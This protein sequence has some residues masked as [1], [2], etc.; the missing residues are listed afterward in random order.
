MG[1]D[2]TEK[3]HR[4][5]LSMIEKERVLKEK[6][7]TGFTFNGWYIFLC[8]GYAKFPDWSVCDVNPYTHDWVQAL[9]FRS[10]KK[11]LEYVNNTAY[12]ILNPKN[13]ILTTLYQ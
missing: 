12:H 10:Y 9:S 1:K 8:D 5:L 7:E 2:Y 3:E 11:A 4:H 6:Y 13:N